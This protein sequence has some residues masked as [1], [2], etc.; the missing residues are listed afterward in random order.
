MK[1]GNLILAVCITFTNNHFI[2]C[3]DTRREF[4]KKAVMLSGA[5]GVSQFLPASIS[6]AFAINPE[7]AAHTWMRSMWCC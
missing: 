4:L 7:R 1:S 2:Y 5:V 3:M 6:K